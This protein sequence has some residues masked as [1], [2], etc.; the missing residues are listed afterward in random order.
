[1][2]PDLCFLFLVVQDLPVHLTSE[3]DLTKVASE[4]PGGKSNKNDLCFLHFLGFLA[5]KAVPSCPAMP[6]AG[7]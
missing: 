4:T 7:P 1:M 6:C 2:F 5:L 3:P